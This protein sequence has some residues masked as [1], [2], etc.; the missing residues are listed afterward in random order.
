M[1]H[2][3]QRLSEDLSEDEVFMQELAEAQL[4]SV[5]ERKSASEILLYIDRFTDVAK[6]LQR[7]VIQLILNYLYQ[8][9]PSSLSATHI[10][11]VFP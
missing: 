4:N 6:P 11:N 8:E 9:R 5:T 10:E 7:R 2:H 3:F 1:H